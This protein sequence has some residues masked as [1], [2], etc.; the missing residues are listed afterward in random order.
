MTDTDR[1]PVSMPPRAQ[2][3]NWKA[4][5]AVTVIVVVLIAALLVVVLPS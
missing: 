3:T 1:E 4:V 2:P 5:I